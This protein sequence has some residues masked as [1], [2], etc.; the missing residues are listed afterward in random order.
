MPA[1][2]VKEALL[3]ACRSLLA[4][5]LFCATFAWWD[6]Y[7]GSR[8]WTNDTSCCKHQLA[9]SGYTHPDGLIIFLPVLIPNPPILFFHQPPH[10]P[11][12]ASFHIPFTDPLESFLGRKF[13]PYDVE[14]P[15][16]SVP[17]S[18][19]SRQA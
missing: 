10:T 18:F 17:V 8:C 6:L 14:I 5:A 19:C 13:A 2:G 16:P 7:R 4:A 15:S 3:G 12:V 9:D 11:V 1:G